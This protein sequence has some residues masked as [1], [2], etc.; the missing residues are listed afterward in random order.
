MTAGNGTTFGGGAQCWAGAANAA[1]RHFRG[2]LAINLS[3][4]NAPVRILFPIPFVT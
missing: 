3:V 4:A 2:S 1:A